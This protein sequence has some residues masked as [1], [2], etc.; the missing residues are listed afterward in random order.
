MIQMIFAADPDFELRL[1]PFATRKFN[2]SIFGTRNCSKE[3]VGLVAA[4]DQVNHQ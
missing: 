2:S 3:G 4:D 1:P